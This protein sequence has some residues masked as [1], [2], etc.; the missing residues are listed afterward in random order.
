MDYPV[1]AKFSED[2]WRQLVKIAMVSSVVF[3]KKYD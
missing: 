2:G 1:Q 3:Y